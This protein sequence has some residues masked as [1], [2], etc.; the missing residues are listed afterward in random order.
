MNF[1]IL[2]GAVLVTV[3]IFTSVLSF[4][5]G[6]PLLLVF[7]ILGL[8]AGEDG[9]GIQF[10]DARAAFFIGS[11]ALALILFDSGF[12]T[13]YSTLRT[14]AL[15]GLSL[16]TFGV[17]ATAGLVGL[18]AHLLLGIGWSESFLL[19]AIVSSTDAAAVFFLLRA[20]GI[21]LRER[22]RATLEV[23]SSSNDPMAIFLT[24]ALVQLI[25]ASEGGGAGGLTLLLDFVEQI[26]LGIV[27]GLLGGYAI[28]VIIDRTDLDIGLYPIIFLS[29]ALAVFAATSLLGGSGFLAVYIAG[30]FAGNTKMRHAVGLRKFSQALTWLGQIV[31]FLTLGLLASPSE[32]LDLLWPAVGIAA[33][34]MI[35]AR[36]AAVYFTTLPFRFGNREVAFTGWVGLRGAVSILLGIV[37]LISGVEDGKLFFNVAFIIVLVSLLVQGWS[38]RPVARWLGLIVPPRSGPIGRVELELPGAGDHE[39]VAYVLHPE[40]RV[41]KGERIPRW[42]RP[43][44]ILRDG[45][46]LRPQTAGRLQPGDHIYIVAATPYVPLLDELFVEPAAHSSDP[47]LYGDF[48]LEP[49]ATLANVADVYGVTVDAEEA[50]LTLRE[51]IHQ[52]LHGDIEPGD[53]VSLAGFDL[54]VRAIDDEHHVKEVGLDVEP[55]APDRRVPGSHWPSL[56]AR[57]L[58]RGKGTVSGS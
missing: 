4:R 42:A 6:A 11:M 44:L 28:R 13:R 2:V 31:M 56:I 22:V 53:R 57:L 12:N 23:E 9:L 32:F 48:M 27:L 40:S 36:P 34:L 43:S 35:V 45:R 14:A 18:V 33:F 10:D 19:G 16:A 37:P 7:L 17:L 15:P 47:Q 25:V 55:G 24:F 39:V 51:F 50:E 54:V 1:A 20:G 41:A 29:L 38:I 58:R 49:D 3:S 8:G 21:N 30:I 26:G 46:S 52:R 5:I